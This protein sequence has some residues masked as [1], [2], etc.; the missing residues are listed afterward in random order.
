[1]KD[2]IRRAAENL[3]AAKR[4]VALTG[5][6]ISVESGI[7]PF[8]G[9]GGIWERV[10]PMV[11]GHIDTF[12]KDPET[13]WR[14]LIRDLKTI[15]D[16][17]APNDGHKGL[18]RLEAMGRLKAVITQNVDGLHQAAGNTEVL[19]FH[20]TCALQRCMD[21]GGRTPTRD[22]DIARL[23]PR[24]PCGGVLRPDWVFFGEA[25]PPEAL[26]RSRQLAAECDL[27]L[28]VGTSAVVHP[29]AYMPVIAR[30]AGALVIEIN[31]ERTPLTGV[32]SDYLIKGGAGEV[33]NALISELEGMR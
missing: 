1:M 2:M 8:R 16:R 13:V 31:P 3:M 7:P 30:D 9:R 19:E 29:A 11:F 25:I 12:E 28:V 20:G 21:C 26:R 18:A 15:I 6:G 17:A 23:P 22:V 27:M 33:M 32:V 4:V 14:V 5:A 24:C 10:D